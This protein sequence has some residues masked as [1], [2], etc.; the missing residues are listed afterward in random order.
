[1]PY[2]ASFPTPAM[3]DSWGEESTQDLLQN[4]SSELSFPS[5]RAKLM[6]EPNVMVAEAAPRRSELVLDR[7]GSDTHS[8]VDTTLLRSGEDSQFSLS[9][10]TETR[11]SHVL[12]AVSAA[13]FDSLDDAVVAY[14]VQSLK[15]NKRLWQEQRLSRIRRLPVLLEQLHLAAQSW[16]EWQRRSFQEQIIKSTEDIVV[17]ELEAHLAAKRPNCCNSACDTEH[18]GQV[19]KHK[20]TEVAD[21]EA[22]VSSRSHST[23][24][25]ELSAMLTRA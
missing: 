4:P 3:T 22:E 10:S 23:H 9:A 20:V 6:P 8:I 12:K 19:C 25:A 11:L 18:P 2:D 14:Y 1:M 15:H 16:G 13:G 5:D 24:C 7:G 21:N 17:A